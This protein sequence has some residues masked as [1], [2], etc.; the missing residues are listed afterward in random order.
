VGVL[1][2]DGRL[3]SGSDGV[4]R[5]WRA[6]GQASTTLAFGHGPPRRV[7]GALIAAGGATAACFRP[8]GAAT[9]VDDPIGGAV[10]AGRRPT[11]GAWPPAGVAVS[12][13]RGTGDP[14][15]LGYRV[16]RR[17]DHRAGFA[18]DVG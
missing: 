12:R 10:S 14:R 9:R 6:D 7:D 3:A 15:R 17:L 2:A 8:A 16:A 5:V 4:I 1:A 18:G 13:W 11:V